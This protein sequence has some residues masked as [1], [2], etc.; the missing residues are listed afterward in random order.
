MSSRPEPPS[1]S[2]SKP[3]ERSLWYRVPKS[4]VILKKHSRGFVNNSSSLIR[5]AAEN[6][7]KL[8]LYASEKSKHSDSEILNS[9]YHVKESGDELICPTPYRLSRSKL[10]ASQSP[11]GETFVISKGNDS[12]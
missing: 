4:K 2:I 5:L 8:H 7:A 6:S 11:I 9:Q 1:Q 3:K 12:I 10:K